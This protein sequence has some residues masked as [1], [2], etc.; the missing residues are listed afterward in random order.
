[1]SN[2]DTL[3]E[4]LFD[5]IAK[6]KSKDIDLDTAKTIGDL[7]QVIINSAK[8]EVDFV[9]ANGGGGSQFFSNQV[10]QVTSTA[11]GVKEV[12][13]HLTVHRLK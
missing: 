4:S 2:I 13:G 9:R 5:A 3:R 6:L 1:M 11:T 8:V 12:S 7:S 10:K